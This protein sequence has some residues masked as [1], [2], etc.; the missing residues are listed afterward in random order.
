MDKKETKSIPI[1]YLVPVAGI[2]FVF[3]FTSISTILGKYINYRNSSSIGTK[4]VGNID[5][6]IAE[7]NQKDFI[8]SIDKQSDKDYQRYYLNN[9]NP[10]S[11]ENNKILIDQCIFKPNK[12]TEPYI[13]GVYKNFIWIYR[14]GLYA[15]NTNLNEMITSENIFVKDPF[16][17]NIIKK[18]STKYK[19]FKDKV[20]INDQQNVYSLDLNDLSA[21]IEKHIDFDKI[22]FNYALFDAKEDS[23]LPLK[24]KVLKLGLI[25]DIDKKMYIK[26]SN[27]IEKVKTNLV[28]SNGK[29]LID[30]T[31]NRLLES[32]NSRSIA[33]IHDDKMTNQGKN[34]TL[35]LVS[36]TGVLQWMM[37]QS[38]IGLNPKDNSRVVID[39]A[40]LN[41]KNQLI[42]ITKNPQ[43]A[44]AFD[45]Q[46]GSI[47]WKY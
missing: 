47:L 1:I 7:I 45:M 33:V 6:Y 35:S 2:I 8:V 10:A 44:F 30:T 40:H 12:Y 22:N 43:S 11:Q 17:R 36:L 38:D 4:I 42:M 18:N 32:E 27:K 14:R 46:N 26:K 34:F 25:G 24:N 9:F 3:F 5:N 29:L 23:F 37:F 39:S 16:L 20:F 21:K 28:F 31:D 13:L 41:L 15:Y 19:L